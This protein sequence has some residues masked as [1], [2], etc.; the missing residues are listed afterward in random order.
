MNGSKTVVSLKS[1]YNKKRESVCDSRS[2]NDDSIC[3]SSDRLLACARLLGLT[4]LELI[5]GNQLLRRSGSIIEDEWER[6][7]DDH[8]R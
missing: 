6:I 5:H 1:V 4:E 3:L 2:L 8:T 7:A